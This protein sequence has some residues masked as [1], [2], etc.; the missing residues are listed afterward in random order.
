ME[1]NFN[2]VYWDANDL[3]QCKQAYKILRM[4]GFSY[5]DLSDL[6]FGNLDVISVEEE[7][8]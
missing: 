6:N 5:E 1:E 7:M 4:E 3:L 8:E 2:G